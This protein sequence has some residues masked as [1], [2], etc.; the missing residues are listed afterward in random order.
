MKYDYLIVGAGFAGS[1]LAE[2]LASQGN[3]ILLVE[4]RNHISG[5]SYD[6]KNEAGIVVHKYGPHIFH[7]QNK[8]VWNYLS[9]F[10]D[11]HEYSH[12]VLAEVDGK[13]VP[14]PFNFNSI[15]ILF[16]E[17]KS[18]NLREKL[19]Q[20]YGE[21][22][23]IP[24]LK[25]KE[26][27]DDELKELADFIYEKIFLGYT[28]KQWDLKPEEL[29]FS[30]TSR[31]PVFLSRDDRYFQDD[32]QA[33]PAQ[34]YT[35]MFEKML[36]HPNIEVLLEVDYKNIIDKISY[37]RMIFTGAIDD[38]FNYK[39]G[40]LPYRSLEF[41]F[42]TLD[43]EQFQETAQVNYPNAHDYTRITEFKHFLPTKSNQTTIAYEYPKSYK[44]GKN[45]P[46]YPIPKKENQELYEKYKALADVLAGKVFFAGRLA[47]YKYYNMDQVVGTA[48]MLFE[49]KLIGK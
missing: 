23:K 2:R 46:Y 17:V 47:E 27:T 25:L 34:G 19:I 33:I 10:T 6:Y 40:C 44:V 43:K 31:I 13:K 41:D 36:D 1:V 4:K 15:D 8:K 26:T 35:A 45:A 48:L 9:R 11:W 3:K 5:N 32:Y 22:V 14:V 18:R 37:D 28:T 12:K 16:D 42:Q 24:I 20:T 29:D 38:F 7:T 21:E 30:V 39:F 49:K